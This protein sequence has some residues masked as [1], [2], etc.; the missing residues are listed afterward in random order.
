MKVTVKVFGSLAQ[1][2]GSP[3]IDVDLSDGAT[4]G[5]LLRVVSE[6]FPNAAPL[7][8]RASFAVNLEVSPWTKRISAAD[9]LALLPPAS[10][11]AGVSVAV[12]EQISV[13]EAVAAASSTEAGGLVVF[14][15]TVRDHSDAGDVERLQYTAYDAMA[16][17]VL[18]EIA[19]EAVE[20]WGLRG[21][22]IRHATGE[23]E[24]GAIT[25]VVVCAAPHRDEAFDACRYV[26]DEL[27]HRVPIWKKEFGSWGER[28][29][30]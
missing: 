1:E 11:G 28:W 29:I 25:I 13:D 4:G 12:G 20:K 30:G 19:D 17:K 2:M 22:A 7:L 3:S 6:R 14:V 23:R 8:S 21:V 9:E 18:R 16:D 24:V 26:V 10:G 5:D 15:G 27:K